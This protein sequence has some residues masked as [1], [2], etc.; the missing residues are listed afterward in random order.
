LCGD[1]N[2]NGRNLGDLRGAKTPCPRDNLEALLGERPN[3]KRRENALAADAVGQFLKSRI[4]EDAAGLVFD[5]LRSESETLR[6]SVALMIAV[7]MVLA[8][9]ERLKGGRQRERTQACGIRSTG[10]D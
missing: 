2:G 8:P 9:F 6:Y 4:F 3:E 1:A 10:A 5:S 7:S